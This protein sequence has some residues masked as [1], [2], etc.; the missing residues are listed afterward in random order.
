[1]V[2]YLPH[3]RISSSPRPKELMGEELLAETQ[4]ITMSH[5]ESPHQ[6][7]RN[8]PATST[9][10]FS[11]ISVCGLAIMYV[12]SHPDA[13]SVYIHD[14]LQQTS[15]RSSPMA[16]AP[17]PSHIH[18]P[19]DRLS[20][21]RF[22]RAMERLNIAT[23]PSQERG[24]FNFPQVMKH[25]AMLN[26]S[27]T[28][29]SVCGRIRKA[30]NVS[31]SSSFIITLPNTP[32]ST[33]S[34]AYAGSTPALSDCVVHPVGCRQSV[35]PSRRRAGPYEKPTRARFTSAIEECLLTSPALDNRRVCKRSRRIPVE[36]TRG[37]RGHCRVRGPSSPTP[38]R[39]P[40]H[41]LRVYSQGQSMDH[42][43]TA[44]TLDIRDAPTLREGAAHSDIATVPYTCPSRSLR[45]GYN[46]RPIIRSSWAPTNH[47]MSDSSDSEGDSL[48]SWDEDI[49]LLDDVVASDD[50]DTCM[51]DAD[52]TSADDRL[53]VKVQH[54]LRCSRFGERMQTHV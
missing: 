53:L 46:L 10:S 15:T 8:S 3:N 23:E 41:S 19:Y 28:S 38:T 48:S 27:L 43:A 44:T 45:L 34:S 39:R 16:T 52:E 6:A 20:A 2:S 4:V 36:P 5:S 13:S 32:R 51:E 26:V 14:Y 33:D 29:F 24:G 21:D 54:V 18:L 42:D 50:V 37:H 9:A 1:M 22:T 47:G 7:S 31:A 25:I 12:P 11:T 30:D 35:T 17:F 49:S 40:P